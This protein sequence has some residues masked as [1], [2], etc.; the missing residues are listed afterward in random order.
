[1]HRH[2]TLEFCSK[3]QFFDS[4]CDTIQQHHAETMPPTTTWL[5]SKATSKS[6][7]RRANHLQRPQ[8]HRCCQGVHVQKVLSLSCLLIFR[9][10][11]CCDALLSNYLC[12]LF[13]LFF[14]HFFGLTFSF[15]LLL[16]TGVPSLFFLVSHWSIA[17]FCFFL[18]EVVHMF[19]LWKA[20]TPVTWEYAEH[21][22]QRGI[23]I[24][25]PS[26]SNCRMAH[27]A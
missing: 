4:V 20:H 5:A 13:F 25:N 27:D 12:I 3:R 15:L 16:L 24:K 6:C 21:R 11:I 9:P 19:F 2:S 1:M 14:L 18:V 10:L 23:K 17:S 22:H 8:P 7:T 26:S